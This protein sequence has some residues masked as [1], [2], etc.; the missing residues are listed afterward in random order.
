MIKIR[1]EG[2]SIDIPELSEEDLKKYEVFGKAKGADLN[3][4]VYLGA[5]H[6]KNFFERVAGYR[7]SDPTK[8]DVVK[9]M[10]ICVT[11]YAKKT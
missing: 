3:H 7:A 8:E 9:G 4:C 5:R 11:F 6:G 2:K 10:K 1:R